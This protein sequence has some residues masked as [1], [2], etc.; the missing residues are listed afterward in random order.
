MSKDGYAEESWD[1]FFSW[2]TVW[3]VSGFDYGVP[4]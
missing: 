1:A 2:F 3:A 4:V